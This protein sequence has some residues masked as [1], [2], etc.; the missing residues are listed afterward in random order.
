MHG[1]E[2][3]EQA[4]RV[5]SARRLLL[6]LRAT[7]AQPLEDVPSLEAALTAPG[8]AGPLVVEAGPGDARWLPA[9][10]SAEAVRRWRPSVP[11]AGA[12]GEQLL[13]LAERLGCMEVVVDPAGPEPMRVPAAG[14][15]RP[16][17]RPL[18]TPIGHDLLR[19]LDREL[20]GDDAVRR[21]WL[22]ELAL[23]G[24]DLLLVGVEVPGKGPAEADRIAA[25][26]RP[27]L[28]PLLP[29]AL[30]DGVDFRAMTDAR[31]AADIAA[32]D[33]PVYRRRPGG[34]PAPDGA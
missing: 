26:L 6:P 19:R 28:A 12:S 21:V 11:V 5:L 4:R 3:G 10:T 31:L 16:R 8:V 24:E 13:A 32:A 17:V 15:H 22:V 18:S 34:E 23:A 2:R 7:G 25:G 20:A 30:Y 27:R 9:F 29:S 33:A 14:G 1:R